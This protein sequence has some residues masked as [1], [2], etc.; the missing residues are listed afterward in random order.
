MTSE[1]RVQLL[2]DIRKIFREEFEAY[3]NNGNAG[4][5]ANVGPEEDEQEI[6]LGDN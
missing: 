1:E 3:V 5:D 4:L 6:E 2:I